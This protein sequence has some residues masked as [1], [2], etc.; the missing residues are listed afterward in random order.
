MDE[1]AFDAAMMDIYVRA[2][3]EADY[4]ATRYLEML[5]DHRGLETARLLIYADKPSDG[6]TALWERGR[7]DLTVEALVVQPKWQTLFAQEPELLNK[8]NKRLAEYKYDPARK[9][10]SRFDPAKRKKLD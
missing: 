4:K 6:Y 3:E 2:L 7:L 10:S 5:H 1:K 8:A 9:K